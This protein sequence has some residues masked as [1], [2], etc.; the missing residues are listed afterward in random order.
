MTFN[1]EQLKRIYDVSRVQIG[2][3]PKNEQMVLTESNEYNEFNKSHQRSF[4][5]IN[6]L[7]TL[8]YY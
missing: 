5:Y 7:I 1:D 2:H 4:K 6:R 8:L 3:L